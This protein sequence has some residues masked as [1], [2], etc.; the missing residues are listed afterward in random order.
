MIKKNIY[1]MFQYVNYSYVQNE[2][3]LINYLITILLQ[4]F[5]FYAVTLSRWVNDRL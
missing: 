2:A 3:I 4:C 1:S 5:L